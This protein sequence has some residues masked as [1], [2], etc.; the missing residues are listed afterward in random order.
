VE[1]LRVLNFDSAFGILHNPG[2]LRR[3]LTIPFLVAATLALAQGPDYVASIE[4]WRAGYETALRAEDGWLTVVGLHWL[5]PGDN[6]AGSAAGS[7]VLLPPAAPARLG[8]FRLEGGQVHFEPAS[9]PGLA[10][11]GRPATATALRADDQ[12]PYD[13]VT[14]GSL[15]LFVIHRGDRFGIRV[16][17]RESQ[18][19]K[20]FTG[21]RWYPVDVRWRVVARFVPYQPPKMI[22]IL[23]VLGQV[24]PQPSPGYAAFDIGGR[25]YRL[26]PTGEG[27]TLF[28]NFRDATSGDTT[29]AAGR[30]LYADAPVN[31]QVVL[32]FNRA[33]NPPCAFSEYA[34]CPL[35]PKQNVLAI[36]VEAGEQDTHHGR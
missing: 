15:T 7:K 6:P 29:Y 33:E 19:R 22:P 35:P 20:A 8:S 23:N 17:D 26:D 9:V 16:R 24:T 12:P 31:G 3:L 30:F 36:R 10:V 21:T 1:D 25:E 2:M 32:D 11:N 27:R 4:R 14:A 18:A 34:T 28:F 13:R 5:E